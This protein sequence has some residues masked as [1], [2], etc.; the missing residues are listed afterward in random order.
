MF[1]LVFLQACKSLGILEKDYFGL[2]YKDKNGD[3]LW[4]NLRNPLQ[5]QLPQNSL[6]PTVE[7]RVKYFVAPQKLIQP[8][9]R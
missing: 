6:R 9:T 8:I 4:I 3:H 1:S 2:Q 7:M 5:E